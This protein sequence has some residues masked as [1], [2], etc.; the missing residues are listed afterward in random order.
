[1]TAVAL[2]IAAVIAVPAYGGGA[3]FGISLARRL[4]LA[5]PVP[6]TRLL[7]FALS[8][9]TW[10]LRIALVAVVILMVSTSVGLLAQVLLAMLG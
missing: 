4:S 6:G 3:V 10:A 2:G 1:M 8:A 5:E 9:L 7:A